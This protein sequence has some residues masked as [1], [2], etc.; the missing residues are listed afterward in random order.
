MPWL[1]ACCGES[2]KP[3]SGKGAVEPFC[4]PAVTA[5]LPLLSEVAG[6]SVAVVLSLQENWMNNNSAVRHTAEKKI[7][8]C[9]NKGVGWFIDMVYNACS[10]TEPA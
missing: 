8:F 3:K 10:F 6:L 2:I 1:S 7:F 4:G 9:I 5:S